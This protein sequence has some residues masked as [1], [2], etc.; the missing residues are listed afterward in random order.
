M[1][2][3]FASLDPSPSARLASP[4]FGAQVCVSVAWVAASAA[5]CAPTLTA[6]VGTSR[7]ICVPL[8]RYAFLRCVVF[9][10]LVPACNCATGNRLHPCL[11]PFSQ[12]PQPPSP[13]FTHLTVSSIIGT[14]MTAFTYDGDRAAFVPMIDRV[15]VPSLPLFS[16][17][18]PVVSFLNLLNLPSSDKHVISVLGLSFT[19]LN[20]TPS[21]FLGKFLG[22]FSGR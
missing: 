4:A 13:A 2:F 12:T 20:L 9:F 14:G 22:R 15:L 17:Q 5:V 7:F 18:A 8:I 10:F 11:S 19:A 1:G 16:I 3:N 6:Q 21:E